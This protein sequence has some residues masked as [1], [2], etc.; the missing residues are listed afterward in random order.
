MNKKGLILFGLLLVAYS[1]A[2]VNACTPPP[3]PPSPTASPS[4][5]PLSANGNNMMGSSANSGLSNAITLSQTAHSLLNQAIERNLDVSGV[6]DSI[7][8][9]DAL[10]ESAQKIARTNPIA[11]CNM[12]REAMKT[13]EQAVKDLEALLS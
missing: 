8:K 6:S 11:A 7:A 5:V 1:I 10:L 12:L 3:P 4:S 9:A 2:S 13:Y